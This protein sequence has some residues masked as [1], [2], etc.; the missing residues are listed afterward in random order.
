MVD[1]SS[2]KS[3]SSK[4]LKLAIVM[5]GSL[6]MLGIFAVPVVLVTTGVGKPKPVIPVVYDEIP[7]KKD[8]D[9]SKITMEDRNRIDCFLEYESQYENLT[10]H[11]CESVR[12]CTFQPTEYRRVPD[13]FFKRQLL[14]YELVEAAYGDYIEKFTLRRS[15]AGNSTYQDAIEYLS[16]QVEYLQD[17]I[18]H[19]KV[20]KTRVFKEFIKI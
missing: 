14:G 2:K 12:S 13:C 17:N 15:R 18:L 4:T 20:L 10:R 3:A 5:A 6:L 11:Q 7:P 1:E 8:F 16:V 9:L 19:V